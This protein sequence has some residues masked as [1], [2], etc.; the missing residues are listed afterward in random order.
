MEVKNMNFRQ[1]NAGMTSDFAENVVTLLSGSALSAI[2]PAVRADLLTL[3]GTLPADLAAARADVLV[4]YDEAIA[5]VSARNAIKSELDTVL[6]RVAASLRAGLAP[7]EQFDLCGFNYPFGPRSR[8]IPAAPV[9][10]SVFGTSNG[11][12][13]GR[14][15]GNNKPASVQYEVW[16]REGAEGEW[17]LL[18]TATKQSFTDWPVKPGQYY[19]YKV[20]AK[21]ATDISAFSGTAVVYGVV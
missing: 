21:A 8:V 14:F 2:D 20:R 19:E 10:L 4:Q 6:S 11:L 7:K 9:D 17:M 3:I 1:M 13:A 18:K 5:S 16:R 15:T 12:N